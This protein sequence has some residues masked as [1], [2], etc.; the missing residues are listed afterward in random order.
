MFRTCRRQKC[1][2]RQ[3]KPT[4]FF[5]S[6]GQRDS[7][8][9]HIHYSVR[10]LWSWLTLRITGSKKQ[11]AEGVALFAVRVYAIVRS[12]PAKHYHPPRWFANM[13]RRPSIQ[14]QLQSWRQPRTDRRQLSAFST[15]GIPSFYFLGSSTVLNSLDGSAIRQVRVIPTGRY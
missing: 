13:H 3:R 6:E 4:M 5:R 7:A 9:L 11:S 2:V 10:E 1:L 14:K 15:L 8:H 12:R